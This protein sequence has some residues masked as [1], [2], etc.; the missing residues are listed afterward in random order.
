MRVVRG[1]SVAFLISNRTKNHTEDASKSVF[2]ALM[3]VAWN[4]VSMWSESH[5]SR[6][7]HAGHEGHDPTHPPTH[8]PTHIQIGI[9]AARGKGT[10]SERH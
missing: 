7:R 3:M 8:P 1:T 9:P 4:I 5:A 2:A 10:S 6:E